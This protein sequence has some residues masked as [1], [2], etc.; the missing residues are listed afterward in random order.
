MFPVISDNQ[1]ENTNIQKVFFTPR[2]TNIQGEDY[3][4]NENHYETTNFANSNLSLYN[5]T[6]VEIAISGNSLLRAGQM[7]TLNVTKNE[8]DKKI[9][10]SGSDFNEEK[11]GKYLISSIHHRFFMVDGSYKTYVTLVRNFRGKPV[12]KQQQ[13]VETT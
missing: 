9:I 7:V 6:E 4:A 13:K 3:K 5:D 11:S 1:P 2:H 12:P 10:E 8:P